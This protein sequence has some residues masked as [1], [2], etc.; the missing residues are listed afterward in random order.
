MK[1]WTHLNGKQITLSLACSGLAVLAGCCTRSSGQARYWSRPAPAY[2]STGSST[3]QTYEQGTQTTQY[4]QTQPGN[5]VVI[6]LY[7]E[8]LNVG[9]REVEAGAVR[10]RKVVRTETINQPVQLR[11]EEVVI[12]R[13]PGNG[14]ATGQEELNQQFQEG[15][16]VIRLKSEVPVIEKQVQPTGKIVVQTRM[17]GDQT[18]IVTQIRREDINVVKEG[19]AQNVIIGQNITTS[20]SSATGSGSEVGGQNSGAA[21]NSQDQQ[22]P[23]QPKDQ[24]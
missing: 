17:T 18:N 10:L 11:H 9:K 1:N 15:E 12:D 22:P 5:N 13:E 8:T 16:T 7:E 6:P 20:S 21:T 2:A 14:T 3:A 19:N 24:Q 4:Q 23:N